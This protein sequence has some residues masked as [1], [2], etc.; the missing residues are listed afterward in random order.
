MF[1]FVG[2]DVSVVLC[3]A[4]IEMLL[5]PDINNVKNWEW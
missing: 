5:V 3:F 4:K 2:N 1:C